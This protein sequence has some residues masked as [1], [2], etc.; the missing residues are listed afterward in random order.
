M[1]TVVLIVLAVIVVLAIAAALLMRGRTR[2]RTLPDESRARYADSWR[3]VEATFVDDPRRAV[4]D[5]D[6]LALAIL[7]ERGGR[8][9][10]ERS[11]PADLRDARRLAAGDG[12]VGETESLRRAMVAY[13]RIV[14]EAVGESTRRASEARRRE[15]I[16]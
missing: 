9:D 8:V 5:A 15:V 10:D 6:G 14:D 2:L 1:T 7:R 12:E 4:R 11:L 13:Q 16:G 3:A